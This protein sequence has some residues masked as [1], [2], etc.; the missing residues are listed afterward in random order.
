V[1]RKLLLVS[2]AAALLTSAGSMAAV[3][4]ETP[5]PTQVNGN[6]WVT[7]VG[8][9]VQV[10]GSGYHAGGG[11][12]GGSADYTPPRCW[13]TPDMTPAEAKAY[14]EGDILPISNSG[15]S[16]GND[17]AQVT[18]KLLQEPDNGAAYHEGDEGL[19]YSIRCQGDVG[20]PEQIAFEQTNP[21]FVF[22]G[23]GFPPPPGPTIDA[24]MLAEIA[25]AFLAVPRTT[26]GSSPKDGNPDAPATVN[27]PTW[28]WAVPGQD[29][30]VTAEIPG[31]Q[32]TV[33]ATLERLQITSVPD[34]ATMHPAGG[35]CGGL[36]TKY[37]DGN[38]G[39]PP[40]GFTFG[41]SAAA[42]VQVGFDAVWHLRW[43]AS[44]G[45]GGDMGTAPF[46]QQ[47]AYTVQEVQ[48]VGN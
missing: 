16:I 14:L 4:Q 44:N 34:G 21:R 3:A 10:H 23:P 46:A 18:R 19:W 39:T 28:L 38:E 40:C 48:V 9:H 43:A 31:L 13:Y 2:V 22:V 20:G 27:L 24:R 12:V 47:L 11:N 33:T 29:V 1:L 6:T 30:D 45:Q 7:Q 25:R 32:S 36:G 41:R 15:G 37:V 26:T 42:P 17:W 35:D 8:R 5:P